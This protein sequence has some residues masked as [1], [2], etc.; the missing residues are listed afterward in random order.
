MSPAIDS[1]VV[2]NISRERQHRVENVLVVKESFAGCTLD[3]AL[4]HVHIYYKQLSLNLIESLL[5]V[6]HFKQM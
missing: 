2:A 6:F 1:N 3:I 4:T 5:G